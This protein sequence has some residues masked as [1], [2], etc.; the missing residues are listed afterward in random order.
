MNVYYYFTLKV[1]KSNSFTYDSNRMSQSTIP[2]ESIVETNKL[3]YL[4]GDLDSL[5]NF[6]E[7][8]CIYRIHSSEITK[9]T[10]R[11]LYNIFDY[12]SANNIVEL[13]FLINDSITFINTENGKRIILYYCSV[14]PNERQCTFRW[15]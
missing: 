4:I 8:T 15:S 14:L 2:L 9:F 6:D 13:S 5:E 11:R 1:N 10:N 12:K 3:D 7:N